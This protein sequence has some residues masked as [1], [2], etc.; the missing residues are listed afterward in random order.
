MIIHILIT[1]VFYFILM[2]LSTNLLGL[3]V[4]SLFSNPEINRLQS[5][6]SS[7]ILKDEI[8]KMQY[9]YKGVNITALILIITYLYLLFHFWNIGVMAVA[10]ILMIGRLPDL[11]WEIKHGKKI[12]IKSAPNNVLTFITTFLIW[13]ALPVLYY[14]IYH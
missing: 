2:F 5:E 13:A 8:K 4:R 14:F 7:N 10:V 12:D 1:V 9:A 6:T 3:F 11:V